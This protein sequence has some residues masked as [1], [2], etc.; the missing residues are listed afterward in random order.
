LLYLNPRWE[1]IEQTNER[2]GI[3]AIW[4][5]SGLKGHIKEKQKQYKISLAIITTYFN[6]PHKTNCQKDHKWKIAKESTSSK[7][8][9]QDCT[10]SWRYSKD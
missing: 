3:E 4:I 8:C 2:L 10:R 1:Y 9:S 7:S 6:G 5:V